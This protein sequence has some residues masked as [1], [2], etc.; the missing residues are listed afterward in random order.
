MKKFREK[1]PD[2]LKAIPLN[3]RPRKLTNR[4]ELSVRKIV[5]GKN[6]LHL[7]FSFALRTREMVQVLIEEKFD[8]SLSL[9]SV[10]NLLNEMGLPP[11]RSNYQACQ[12]DSSEVEKWKSENYP[13]IVRKAKK[14]GADIYFQD[15]AGVRS[16]Y[17]VRTTLGEKGKTPVAMTTGARFSIN[18]ISAISPCGRL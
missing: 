3:G 11:Q 17:H 7:K 8:V 5:V 9:S 15:E 1:R 18:M 14:H 13:K 16:D 2:S 12:Q 10:S 4:Q 6:H